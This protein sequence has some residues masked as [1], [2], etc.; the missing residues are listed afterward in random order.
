MNPIETNT[1]QSRR[2]GSGQN[3]NTCIELAA[4]RIRV[5]YD[6]EMTIQVDFQRFQADLPQYLKQVEAGETLVVCKDQQPIAEIRPI[7]NKRPLGLGQ[8]DITFLPGFDEPLPKEMIDPFEG[9]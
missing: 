6:A 2:R 1:V 3:S 7:R 4:A 5:A 9:K 8:G